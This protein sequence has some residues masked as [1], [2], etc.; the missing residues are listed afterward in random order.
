MRC[1]A[2]CPWRERQQSH[3][4]QWAVAENGG[5]P[6]VTCEGGLLTPVWCS[7]AATSSGER[8]RYLSITARTRHGWRS[9]LDCPHYTTQRDIPTIP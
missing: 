6:Q 9:S 8:A 4:V 1:H 3:R 5:F 7:L 2:A